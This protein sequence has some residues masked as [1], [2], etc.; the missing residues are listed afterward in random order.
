[1]K[2]ER[3]KSGIHDVEYGN[4]F[5]FLLCNEMVLHAYVQF[6]LPKDKEKC[7]AEREQ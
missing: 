2:T 6:L 7:I 4:V 5:H 3:R 1:V